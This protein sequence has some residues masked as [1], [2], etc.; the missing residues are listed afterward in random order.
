MKEIDWIKEAVHIC[1]AKDVSEVDAARRFESLKQQYEQ[2]DTEEKHQILTILKEQFDSKDSLYLYSVFLHY[3]E[4]ERFARAL[5][6]T[7]CTCSFDV[8]T[9]SMVEFHMHR[10]YKNHRELYH[11][12][13]AFHH[14]NVEK[15]SALLK[16]QL[17][18]RPPSGRHKKRIVIIT[19]QI[20]KLRHAPTRVVCN[21]AYTLKKMGYDLLLFACPSDGPLSEDIWYAAK[22]MNSDPSFRNMPLQIQYRG[23][24]LEGYQINMHPANFKEYHMMFRLIY[25]WNPM[26]VLNLGTINPVADVAS[27]FTTL[28]A[29]EM[30]IACPVSEGEIL[31]R[32]EHSEAWLEEC[33]AAAL[34]KN[35]SQLFMEDDFPVLPDDTAV[36]CSRSSI[37]LAKG[38]FLV[39]VI[40]NRLDEEVDTAFASVM[41]AL[42]QQIPNL[43]FVIIGMI[44]TAKALLKEYLDEWWNSRIHFLGYRKDL[45][46]ILPAL[47]LYLNP[48]RSGGGFSSAMALV[49]GIPVVTLPHCDVANIVGDSFT[50]TDYQEMTE[51]VCRY[52]TDNEFYRQQASLARKYKDQNTD[53]RM[54]EYAEKLVSGILR[55]IHAQETGQ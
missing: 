22:H 36:P 33:Y 11:V 6:E 9:G 44:R 3:M 29:C 15:F 51:I 32:Y 4:N 20:L 21:F 42:L 37:G 26:F 47:D 28:A 34:E 31:V 46:E 23:Q 50:V 1:I 18:Y 7:A 5:A 8:V 48:D 2:F 35:Q 41:A 52:A 38:R 12:L 49:S 16:L 19:E 45:A 30:N 27:R 17:T 53:A 54:S 25:E 40:G 39:A 13:R 24:L 55:T 10:Y 43:D 14:K